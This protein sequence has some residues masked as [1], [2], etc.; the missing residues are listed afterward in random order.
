[1]RQTRYLR[2]DEHEE[3]VRS[4][5]WAEAQARSLGEDSYQ[6]KWVLISLHN[7]VQGFMVLALWQGITSHQKGGR[8]D[9]VDC[10]IFASMHWTSYNF[11]AGKRLR[12]YGTKKPTLCAPNAHIGNLESPWNL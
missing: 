5:E 1:M 2:T 3:A 10:H 9:W 8:S 4:L 6:W 11:V 12:F 7:A